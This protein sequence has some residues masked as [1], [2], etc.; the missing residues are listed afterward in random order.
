MP[1][2]DAP[3]SSGTVTLNGKEYRWETPTLA[4]LEEYENVVGPITD[5]KILNT[6][7]AR[8]YLVSILLRKHHPELT[9]G[10]VRGW[11][12]TVYIESWELI[13]KAIPLY[14]EKEAS[15]NSS[16]D[17]S[18]SSQDGSHPEPEQSAS[19]TL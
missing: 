2:A 7:K 6:V 10:V 18:S 12:A 13:R 17:S 15:P 3:A 4:L 5:L 11:P 16:S 19:A 1:E 14:Q 8:Y 9:P